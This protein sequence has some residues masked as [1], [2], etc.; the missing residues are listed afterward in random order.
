MQPRRIPRAL[1]AISSLSIDKVWLQG[2]FEKQ[3]EPQIRA[4]TSDGAHTHYL[5]LAD[6]TA[7]TQEALDLVLKHATDHPVVT[8][9]CNLA[10]G[11]PRVNLTQAPFQNLHQSDWSDYAWWTRDGV[12]AYP[13]ELVSSHFAGACLT[14]MPKEMWRAFPFHAVT[15][16]E[17]PRGYCSDWSLSV[18][19][20]RAQI[21]I[22]APRGAFVE[23][24]KEFEN[25]TDIIRPEFR[26]LIGQPD[27][28]ST[29]RWEPD[30][31]EQHRSAGDVVR[32]GNGVSLR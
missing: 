19:L 24:L 15:R 13:D 1:E 26:L 20:Q 30:F 16:P 31:I 28:P 23:H 25:S 9:Y 14:C 4:V 7:P 21:P 29:L 27:F 12:E 18:R 11:S 5:L 2:F 17:Q 6:D 3:L 32:T 8:G 22:V 10:A